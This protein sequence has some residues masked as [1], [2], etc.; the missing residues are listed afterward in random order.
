MPRITVLMPVYN[1]M[2]YIPEAV[3]SVLSQSL[4]DWELVISDNG[5]LDE[6][7]AY[8]DSLNDPRIRV[9]KQDSNLGIFGNLNFLLEQASSPIAKILCSDD[10]LL[11]GGLERIAA[12][13]EDRPQCA[14]SRCWASGD[15]E[16]F[17]VRGR[18]Y[19]E[20][21]L[22]SRLNPPAASLA[23]AA[24]G[25]LVGNL[26]KAAC[27]PS[28]VLEAGGFDQAFPY[29]G[30]YEGWMRVARRFGLDLQDEELIFERRHEQQNSNLLNKNNELVPQMN[31]LLTM[32]SQHASE[33]DR[34]LLRLH[35]SIH[36]L[37]RRVP[38]FVRHLWAG[39][40]KVAMRAWSLPLG[41]SALSCI[42][43]YPLVKFNFA[44][45]H[46]TTQK[47]FDRIIALNGSA[48]V[49]R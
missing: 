32:M 21:K 42:A 16:I 33:S 26:S 20:G 7:R 24:F 36:F 5:S 31:K 41:I 2:P 25:N 35:W 29:A 12:F 17:S 46:R 34:E 9:F 3:N 10:A 44:V 1:G 11:E 19:F 37:S 15:S 8:L 47:L 23:F 38:R 22:P 14:V 40:F 18:A 30:D 6:T 48:H 49:H 43:S 27:R 45:A 13:M 28:M 4:A 39:K